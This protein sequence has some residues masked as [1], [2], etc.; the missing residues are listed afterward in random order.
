MNHMKKKRHV[1][2]IVGG[3]RELQATNAKY[4][5]YAMNPVFLLINLIVAFLALCQAC[6]ITV[7]LAQFCESVVKSRERMH[8]KFLA[9]NP[10]ALTNPYEIINS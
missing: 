3:L 5:L 7:G 10:N 1:R 8:D 4:T 2:D 6:I 9:D